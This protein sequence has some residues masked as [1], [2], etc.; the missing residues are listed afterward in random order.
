MCGCCDAGYGGATEHPSHVNE[1]EIFEHV[2][3][4][5]LAVIPVRQITSEMACR[6][7]SKSLLDLNDLAE[8]PWIVPPWRQAIT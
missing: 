4:D 2:W 6:Q 8:H 7:P 5:M 3:A 1:T